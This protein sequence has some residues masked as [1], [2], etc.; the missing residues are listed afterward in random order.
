MDQTV[1]T[2]LMLIVLQVTFSCEL[3]APTLSSAVA[4][5]EHRPFWTEKSAY[6]EGDELFV[7]GIRSKARTAEEGRQQ[8]FIQGKIE[9]TNYAQ[10]SSLEAQGVVIETQMTYEEDNADGTVNVFRLLH[11]PIAK[12]VAIQGRL[13]NQTQVQQQAL[14][15]ARRELS[16]AQ[17][18]LHQK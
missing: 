14:D 15:Q 1:K 16:Q 11:V 9:L 7:V 4:L 5:R 6:V 2:R 8:A 3:I 10:I 17:Y 13:A 12:L 18:S